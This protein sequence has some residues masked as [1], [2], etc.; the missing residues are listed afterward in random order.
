MRAAC[1]E[2]LGAKRLELRRIPPA[3]LAASVVTVGIVGTLRTE[4]PLKAFVAAHTILEF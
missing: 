2:A 1:V 3:R 4:R